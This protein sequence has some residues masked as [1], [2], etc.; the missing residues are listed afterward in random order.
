MSK[1]WDKPPINLVNEVK[2]ASSALW[3][4]LAGRLQRGEKQPTASSISV[5]LGTVL[6]HI[7]G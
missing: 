3:A 1:R 2:E 5:I 4:R 6:E 7:S